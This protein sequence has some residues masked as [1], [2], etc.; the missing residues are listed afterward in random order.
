MKLST[1]LVAVKKITSNKL[2]ST[3][4]DDEIEK[5]AQLILDS[6]G[7]INPIVVRRTSLQSYEVIDGDFEYY[8][9]ARAREIDPRKGEMIGV[10]IIEPENEEALTNQIQIFRQQ[11]STISEKT[12]F[13][14]IDFE[15]FLINLEARFEKITNQVLEQATANVKLENEIKALKKQIANIYEPL[16]VF[17]KLGKVEIANKLRNAGFAPKKAEQIAES[18]E[19]ERSKGQF[20]SLNDVVERV[21]I[22]HGKKMNKAISSEKMLEIVDLWSQN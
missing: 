22:P 1:S 11:K 19:N 21:R 10:F 3:F 9:A 7:V 14:S 4:A 6:E 5:A 13:N 12:N 2:R 17:N 15:K 16:K 8:A 20:K 18:V